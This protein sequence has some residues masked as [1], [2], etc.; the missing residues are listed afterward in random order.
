MAGIAVN[1]RH[2]TVF[3]GPYEDGETPDFASDLETARKEL[4][5]DRVAFCSYED[6]GRFDVTYDREGRYE[7]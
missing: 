6:G 7:S 3:E 2:E 5:G 1:N 4:A